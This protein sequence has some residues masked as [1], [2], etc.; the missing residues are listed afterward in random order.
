MLCCVTFMDSDQT[1]AAVSV[2]GEELVPVSP[3]EHVISLIVDCGARKHDTFT[4]VVN[5]I[6]GIVSQIN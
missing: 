4:D 1:V 6:L 2:F 3:C 5:T